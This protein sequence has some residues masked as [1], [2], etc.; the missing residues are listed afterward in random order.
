MLLIRAA[1]SRWLQAWMLELPGRALLQR[2]A[3]RANT[4]ALDVFQAAAAMSMRRV[5][6]SERESVSQANIWQCAGCSSLLGKW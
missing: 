2:A 4:V 3:H 6:V 5:R 1:G